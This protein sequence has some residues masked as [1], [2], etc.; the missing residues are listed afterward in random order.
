MKFPALILI[1]FMLI[2]GCAQNTQEKPPQAGNTAVNI[3]GSNVV[4]GQ[5]EPQEYLGNNPG[6][7][8]TINAS[9]GAI[10]EANKTQMPADYRSLGAKFQFAEGEGSKMQITVFDVGYGESI[11][12]KKGDFELLFDAGNENSGVSKKLQELG[13]NKIEAV[14][15]TADDEKRWGGLSQILKDFPVSEVWTSGDAISPK[16]KAGVL[17][18][19]AETGIPIRHPQDGDKLEYNGISLTIL[20]PPEKRLTG[21]PDVNSVVAKLTHGDFC[22][23][24]SSN[25]EGGVESRLIGRGGIKCSILKIGKYGAGSAT[26]PNLLFA[27]SP[28]EAIISVGN[29]SDGNPNPTI[30]ERIRLQG[31]ALYRTDINGDISIE[32]DGSEYTIISG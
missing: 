26:A 28:K 4:Y 20:N 12:V 11:L 13:A 9:G 10:K 6:Y 3:T 8:P 5:S 25:M 31:I 17:D 2:L 27:V 32:S 15:I 18:A 23:I 29:N 1:S 21:N 30:L 22:I 24:L 14:V 19:A 16:F 7:V